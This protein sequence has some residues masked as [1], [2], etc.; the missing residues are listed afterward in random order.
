MSKD[1]T[2]INKMCHLIV[3]EGLELGLLQVALVAWVF[4]KHV[5]D[6]DHAVFKF[7]H[8]GLHRECI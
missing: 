2:Y 6:G 7:W 4:V 8:V 3:D 1:S 5:D